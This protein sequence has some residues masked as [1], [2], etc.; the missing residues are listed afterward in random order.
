MS[1]GAGRRALAILLLAVPAAA[2]DEGSGRQ[3]FLGARILPGSGEPIDDGALLVR[4]GRVTS[5]GP[6]WAGEI[7]ADAEVVDLS[8]KFVVP[9]LVDAHAHVGGTQGLESGD[10]HHTDEIVADQLA[11]YARYGVT[12]VFSLG[13]DRGPGFRAASRRESFEIDRARLFVAGPVVEAATPAEAEREVERAAGLG[14]DLIKIRVDDFFDTRDKMPPHVFRAV[15]ESAH[16]RGLRVAA[17]VYELE[18]AKALVEAGADLLAHSVRDREVDDELI[19]LMRARDVCLCPT[20]TRDVSVF[21]YAE[22]PAFFDDPF[23]LAEVDPA[24]VAALEDPARQRGVAADETAARAREALE[25]ARRNLARLADSGVPIAFGTDSGP[26]GRF[27]GFF[28]HLELEM[29]V[30]AG[31]TP[32]RALQAA[33]VDA[34]RC[35]GHAGR[36]G[37]LE[38]GAWA[39]F[40]VLDADPAADIRNLRRIDSVWIAGRRVAGR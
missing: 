32:A 19:G 24:V 30:A 4:Y 13:G 12:S 7:P 2:Q 40:V 9:G 39:D 36:I 37:A 18:D 17:H 35:A 10:Q 33:T 14:A 29:M 5:V 15:I 8:G 3:A 6:R 23:F 11:R 26:P 28:E 38:P 1:R 21:A 16:A 27:Q 31:L 20:L 25:I 34:A 22:R